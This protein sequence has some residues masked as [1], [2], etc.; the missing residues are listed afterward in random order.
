M[1]FNITTLASRH[2]VKPIFGRITVPVMILL[3]R[4]MT[5][6]TEQGIYTRQSTSLNSIIYGITGLES[7]R[8][9]I[10][11]TLVFTLLINFTLFALVIVF[12][13]NFAFWGLS[14]FLFCFTTNSLAFWTLPIAFLSSFAFI[15][16]AISLGALNTTNFAIA[17]M[18]VGMSFIFIKLRKWFDLFA[19]GTSFDYYLLSH[20]RLLV[21]RLRLEPVAAY[22]A[23]GSFYY[24]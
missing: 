8:V 5:I 3:S 23:V 20:N 10:L 12:P 4:F 22:T 14:I 11:K 21:R 2:Y 19:N 16:L 17:T 24:R 9:F 15:R 7:L 13:C 1:S 6:M 18:I